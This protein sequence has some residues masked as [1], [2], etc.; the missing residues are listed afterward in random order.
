[1]YGPIHLLI[2]GGLVSHAA[3]LSR[4]KY[5]VLNDNMLNYRFLCCFVKFF[6]YRYTR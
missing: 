4:D 6:C 2:V 1:M 3:V 5:L